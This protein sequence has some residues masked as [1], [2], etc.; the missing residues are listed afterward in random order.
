MSLRHERLINVFPEQ[1]PVP[2]VVAYGLYQ[3]QRNPIGDGV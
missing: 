1:L 3:P 2:M